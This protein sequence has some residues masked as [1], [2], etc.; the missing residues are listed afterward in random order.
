MQ[1]SFDLILINTPLTDEFGTQLAL[2]LA[3]TPSRGILLLVKGDAYESIADKLEDQ[4]I[5]VVPKPVSKQAIY[6]AVR[7]LVAVRAK[8]SRIEQKNASLQAKMEE[9]RVVNRAKWIL[10][11]HLNMAE[12]QAHHYIEKQAMDL[13]SSK[14]DIA[15]G[16]IKTYEG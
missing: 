5:V 2:E 3:E 8:I 12:G 10:I 11:K 14:G 9:I 13:R 7:I 1:T 6:Q 4:G 16:I 15:R